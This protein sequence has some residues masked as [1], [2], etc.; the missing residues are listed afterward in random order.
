MSLD[1]GR[2]ITEIKEVGNQIPVFNRLAVAFAKIEAAINQTAQAAGVDSTAQTEPPD[3]PSDINVKANGGLV[4]VTLSDSSARTR[5]LNYFVEADTEPSFPQPHVEHLGPSRGKF[6][7]LPSKDDGGNPQLWYFRAYSMNPGS[8][9]RSAHQVYGGITNPTGVNV[10][11]NANLT[12]LPSTGSGTAS[13]T[14][15]QSGE[16]FGTAQFSSEAFK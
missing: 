5:S 14:G 6:L 1:L 9:A 15:R 11:G 3:P 13:T 10:G 4:H 12:P 2:F 7:S 8:K 16:G